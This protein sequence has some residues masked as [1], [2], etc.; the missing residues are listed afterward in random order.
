LQKKPPPNTTTTTKPK[1]AT[2]DTTNTMNTT[3]NPQPMIEITPQTYRRLADLLR[4]RIAT[5]EWINTSIAVEIATADPLAAIEGILTLTAIVYRRTEHY[6]EG[7]RRPIT[8]IVPVWWEFSTEQ[9]LN[10]FS[11]AE[12]KTMLLEND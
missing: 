4:D 7:P 3:K 8:D 1:K 9:C 11:F 10:D 5:A 2:T 6:P 12:L